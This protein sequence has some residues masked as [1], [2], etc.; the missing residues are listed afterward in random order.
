MPKPGTMQLKWGAHAPWR[1]GF[2]VP[3]E[4]LSQPTRTVWHPLRTASR[5]A[6][7]P[8]GTREGACAPR[9]QLNRSGLGSRLFLIWVLVS[10]APSRFAK[11]RVIRPGP[12][13]ANRLPRGL[14]YSG[15]SAKIGVK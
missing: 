11:C 8:V 14:R 13:R 1:A 2:R 3:A 10:P 5:P 15:C 4:P 12:K 9:D 6:R 7:A